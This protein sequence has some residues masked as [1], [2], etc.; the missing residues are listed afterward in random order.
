[1]LSTQWIAPGKFSPKIFTLLLLFQYKLILINFFFIDF[2]HHN[3][4]NHGMV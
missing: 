4:R 3:S 1:M 2:E